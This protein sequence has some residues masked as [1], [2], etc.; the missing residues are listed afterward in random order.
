MQEIAG[1]CVTSHAPL[2]SPP[3]GQKS[4]FRSRVL[5]FRFDSVSLKQTRLT[6]YETRPLRLPL[7][8]SLSSKRCPL[9]ASLELTF[10]S[11]PLRRRFSLVRRRQACVIYKRRANNYCDTTIS[12]F[13][14]TCASQTKSTTSYTLVFYRWL[15]GN[16]S[17]KESKQVRI[18]GELPIFERFS[19]AAQAISMNKNHWIE[20]EHE[21]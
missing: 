8:I 5:N 20:L 18:A 16:I 15:N 1:N 12:Y 7:V 4:Y 3:N 11:A 2:L 6:R 9:A 17:S 19:T 21:I 14:A 10:A 13:S